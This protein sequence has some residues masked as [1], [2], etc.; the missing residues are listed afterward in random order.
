ML[1]GSSVKDIW[2]MRV[3]IFPVQ[4]ESNP[5]VACDRQ[6]Y[7]ALRL[8]RHLRGIED[9]ELLT[10]LVADPEFRFIR[11]ES[12][13]MGSMAN[14]FTPCDNPVRSLARF[15]IHNVKAHSFSQADIRDAIGAVH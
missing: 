10:F 3:G 12:C 1:F 15:E 7:M 2:R 11:S 5:A 13:P 6:L 14:R 9:K 4:A 8:R